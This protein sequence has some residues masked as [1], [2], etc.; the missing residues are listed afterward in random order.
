M[1]QYVLK[2]TDVLGKIAF[3]PPSDTGAQ[4]CIR[5]ELR[6][7]RDKHSDYVLVTFQPPKRPRTTGPHS[8]NHK[9]NGMLM[10]ICNETYNDYDT[11]KYCVK[12]IAV[13]KMGY[14]YQTIAG[15]ILPKRER[16]CNTEECSK[17]IEATYILAAEMGIILREGE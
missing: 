3:E 11:V 16:D 8:Q 5:R 6:K 15:H 2:R 9:L 13:E 12:M 1:T 7:C 14:P 17:L 10:Q 4:E